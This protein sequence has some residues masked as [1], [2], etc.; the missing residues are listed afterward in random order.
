MSIFNKFK[1]YEWQHEWRVALKKSSKNGPLE[2]RLGDLSDIASVLNTK[3]IIQQPLKL[4]K[5]TL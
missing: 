3:D 2:L 5:K 1:N 4:I